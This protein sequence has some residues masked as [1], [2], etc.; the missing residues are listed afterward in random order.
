MVLHIVLVEDNPADAE[1]LKTALEQ[2]DAPV[3]VMLLKDGM[4][5]MEYLARNVSGPH[6]LVLLDLNLPRVSGFE[7]LERI[8]ANAELKSLPIVV[9]SGSSD[10]MEIERCYRAGANSYVCKPTHLDEIFSTVE[11]LVN[12]WSKCV[13]LPSKRW[14]SQVSRMAAK[15]NGS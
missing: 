9:M 15:I 8:R 5:A 6:D 11:H 14:T 1:M 12:Y 3:E 4:Q 2:A 13:K 7:V 10:P